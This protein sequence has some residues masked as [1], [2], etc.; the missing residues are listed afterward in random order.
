MGH[1]AAEDH[2]DLA[3]GGEM[4][5]CAVGGDDDHHVVVV[6]GDMQMHRGAHQL[7]DIHGA[8]DAADEPL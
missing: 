1:I 3:A 7:T 5:R 8:L 6:G 4:G 2:I